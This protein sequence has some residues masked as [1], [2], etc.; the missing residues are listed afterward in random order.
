MPSCVG[1]VAR[2]HAVEAASVSGPSCKPFH[3]S[4]WM[5]T[6][7]ISGPLSARWESLNDRYGACAGLLASDGAREVPH[8]AE[9]APGK[10]EGKPVDR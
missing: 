1:L 6:V 7:R 3:T 2:E 10:T 9:T 4:A 8:Q 5:C